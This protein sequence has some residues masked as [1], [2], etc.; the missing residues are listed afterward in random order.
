[1]QG[2]VLLLHRKRHQML[3]R[4]RVQQEKR[5]STGLQSKWQNDQQNLNNT[6]YQENPFL[7]GHIRQK[8]VVSWAEQKIMS[9]TQTKQDPQH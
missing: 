2:E 8:S 3:M 1:M 4:W 5:M 6:T 9:S 7:G